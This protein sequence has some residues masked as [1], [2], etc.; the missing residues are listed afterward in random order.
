MIVERGGCVSQPRRGVIGCG[1][2]C[3][4]FGIETFGI[5][6]HNPAFVFHQILTLHIHLM[7][8][9]A[10]NGVRLLVG[11]SPL[12][13]GDHFHD[14]RV[15]GQFHKVLD[16]RYCMHSW[17]TNPLAHRIA[18]RVPPQLGIIGASKGLHDRRNNSLPA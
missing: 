14:G 6:K 4:P 3:H 18:N 8:K 7:W 16:V 13:E 5:S 11:S 15:V 10:A 1:E 2:L 9:G 12:G 17:R